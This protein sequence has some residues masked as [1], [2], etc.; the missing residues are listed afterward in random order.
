MQ[1]YHEVFKAIMAEF[2]KRNFLEAALHCKGFLV[3]PD[4]G[5][6]NYLSQLE[7]M[8]AEFSQSAA[9]IMLDQSK[10]LEQDYSRVRQNAINLFYQSLD[11][12]VDLHVDADHVKRLLY[13]H[14]DASLNPPPRLMNDDNLKESISGLFHIYYKSLFA[15]HGYNF[16]PDKKTLKPLTVH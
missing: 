8:V 9:R 1:N 7:M 11:F 16:D 13:E 6:G 2:E 15:L 5:L 3:Q 10:L 12:V 4:E 14:V